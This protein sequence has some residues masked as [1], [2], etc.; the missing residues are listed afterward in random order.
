MEI[1]LIIGTI[2]LGACLAGTIFLLTMGLD[3]PKGIQIFTLASIIPLVIC[4]SL[5]VSHLDQSSNCK[6][7]YR[8][9]NV[10]LYEKVK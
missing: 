7:K 3:T 5:M 1:V 4:F 6:V 10:E 9:V 8:K 2:S